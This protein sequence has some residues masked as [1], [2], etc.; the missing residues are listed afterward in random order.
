MGYNWEEKVKNKKRRLNRELK[1]LAEYEKNGVVDGKYYYSCVV[2]G[3]LFGRVGNDYA[4]EN[5]CSNC[6]KTMKESDLR[7]KYIGLVGATIVDISIE[8][9]GLM[10]TSAILGDITVEKDGKKHVIKLHHEPRRI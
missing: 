4:K 9:R 6:W 3:K 2:C 8:A 1:E 7:E 5:Y 10:L